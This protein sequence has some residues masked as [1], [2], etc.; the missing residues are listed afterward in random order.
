MEDRIVVSMVFSLAPI[1][2]PHI[3]SVLPSMAKGL[4]RPYK[5]YAP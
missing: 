2:T 4:C 5:C 1:P 3:T